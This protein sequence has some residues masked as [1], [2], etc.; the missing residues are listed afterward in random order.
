MYYSF[1]VSVWGN[2]TN[3]MKSTEC[4]LNTLGKSRYAGLKLCW[5][6]KCCSHKNANFL[7][8]RISI[9]DLFSMLCKVTLGERKVMLLGSLSFQG[10]YSLTVKYTWYQIKC[11]STA[12]DTTITP[13]IHSKHRQAQSHKTALPTQYNPTTTTNTT[14]QSTTFPNT[15][16][17]IYI[18]IFFFYLIGFHQLPISGK[19][20]CALDINGE[21][22]SETGRAPMLA[23]SPPAWS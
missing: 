18:S 17:E 6:E 9:V 21:E 8:K 2:N 12:T 7:H 14:L 1:G 11:I 4:E 3:L 16:V 20:T 15:L 5:F 23:P 22:G 10:R 13:T 19:L